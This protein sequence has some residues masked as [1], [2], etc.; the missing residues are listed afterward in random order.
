[1]LKIKYPKEPKDLL[2][3]EE[4]Y[5]LCLDKSRQQEIDKHLANLLHNGEILTLK[6]LVKL[7]FDELIDI[8]PRFVTYCKTRD[9]II[10][11][12]KKQVYV[13]DFLELFNYKKNQPSIAAFFMRQNSFKLNVCHYCGIDYVNAFKDIEDYQD[14]KHFIN[15]ASIRDLQY[16]KGIGSVTANS[17]I[18]NR[19]YSN[20]SELKCSKTIKKVINDF[21][22]SNSHNHFTLD[23]VLPQKTHRFYS[24]C[25]YNLVPSCYSCNSK[26]KGFM[27]FKINNDLKNVSPTSGSYSLNDD[28]RFQIYYPNIKFNDIKDV[29]EFVLERKIFRNNNHLENYFEMFKIGGRYSFQKVQILSLI[30][31]KIN[32]PPSKIRELSKKTGLSI[33][34][35]NKR[36][37]GK[38]LFNESFSNQPMIKLKRDVAKN[39]KIKGVI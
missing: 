34:E 38:E 26:F 1:M 28:F 12:K 31:N 20:V 6:I 8:E 35:I 18:S 32:Y 3:F 33:N 5:Y 7:S 11:K 19:P 23:H 4:S 14:G 21:N 10:T 29:S 24:L 27:S 30:E 17:I 15:K 16:I 13:N 39:I 22:F 2:K 25:L 9:K 37:F 36:I